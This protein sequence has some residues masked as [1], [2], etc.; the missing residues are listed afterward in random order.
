MKYILTYC[1][2]LLLL[3]VACHETEE[4]PKFSSAAISELMAETKQ[5][6]VTRATEG[7]TAFTT[8]DEIYVFGFAKPSPGVGQGDR[9][10]PDNVNFP[11]SGVGLAFTYGNYSSKERFGREEDDLDP[12][13]EM[14]FWR[15]GQHH[16]FTAYYLDSQAPTEVISFAMSSGGLPEE[17]FLWGESEEVYFSGESV[18]VPKIIFKHQLSRIRVELIHDMEKSS[19][20]GFT[21]TQ[22]D[23]HLD[24]IQDEFNVATGEW[25]N[26]P[27][28]PLTLTQLGDKKLSTIEALEVTHITD[29]DWWTLP[30]CEIEM[31]TLHFE[32]DPNPKEVTFKHHY[33]P[34]AKIMTKAGY[35][36]VLRLHIDDV[37]PIIF[38]ATLE[39]WDVYNVAKEIDITD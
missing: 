10:M 11:S 34:N 1:F 33:D 9:F 17:D 19:A 22:L 24:K 35:I 31:L 37:L 29:N 16:K 14:G 32:E 36:T 5:I 2:S 15:V 6:Q 21:I 13:W 39:D 18:I 26:D 27:S 8:G 38:T 30:D 3:L 12:N 23:V 20:E 4:M 25:K 28:S 7:K